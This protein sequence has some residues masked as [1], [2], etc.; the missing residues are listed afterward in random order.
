MSKRKKKVVNFFFLT[1][2]PRKI[3]KYKLRY[4]NTKYMRS[5]NL[6]MSFAIA[7]EKLMVTN[8]MFNIN[9][10]FNIRYN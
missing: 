2:L 10:K 7:C 8:G 4:F 3:Y 6:K 5:C 1:L 9:V